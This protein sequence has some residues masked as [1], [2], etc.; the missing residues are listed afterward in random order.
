MV[1]RT[2]LYSFLTM[3]RLSLTL[4]ISI[5]LRLTMTLKEQFAVH[6]HRRAVLLSQ[7]TL[8]SSNRF[9]MSVMTLSNSYLSSPQRTTWLLQN[10]KIY[11][12]K[13]YLM[14]C[15]DIF[16]AYILTLKNLGLSNLSLIHRSVGLYLSLRVLER[17]FVVLDSDPSDP[18]KSYLTI[19]NIPKGYIVRCKGTRRKTISKKMWVK[20]AMKK[21]TSSLW[22]RSYTDKA[23]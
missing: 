19:W 16:M 1:R 6:G 14:T 10:S 18:L 8:P 2:P 7:R 11:A 20:L 22:G 3:L 4:F 15:F 5:I 21:L 12:T 9:T 17:K 13:F 23:F